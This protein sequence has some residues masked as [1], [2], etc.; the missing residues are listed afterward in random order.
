MQRIPS[1][2][3]GLAMSSPTPCLLGMSQVEVKGYRR[4]HP[5][6]LVS[7]L[8]PGENVVWQG[9]P[10]KWRFVIMG[11]LHLLFFVPFSL[12]WGGFFIYLEALAIQTGSI[13]GT[14]FLSPFFLVGLYLIGG[15]FWAGVRCWRNTYYALTNMRVLIRLGTVS[16][17]VTSLGLS[18]I[19]SATLHIKRSGLGHINFNAEGR[20]VFDSIYFWQPGPSWAVVAGAVVMVPSFRYIREP[21]TVYERLQSLLTHA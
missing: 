8:V 12:A 15:R 3:L 17:K 5:N 14:L 13:A 1:R 20:Y 18:E 10:E 11:P 7:Q 4:M 21:E 19:S 2:I 16:P 6:P 9:K